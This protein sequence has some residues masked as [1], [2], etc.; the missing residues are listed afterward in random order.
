MKKPRTQVSDH[1]VL[2][3]LERGLDIDVEGLRMALGHEVDRALAKAG[4][5][6]SEVDASCVVIGGLRYVIVPGPIVVTIT[7][8]KS[9]PLRPARG[10]WRR[11]ERS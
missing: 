1:A 3:Y 5:L 11:G 7:P 6:T 8:A 9:E 2:R 10:S 4:P